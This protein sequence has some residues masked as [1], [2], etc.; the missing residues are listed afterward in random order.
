MRR[1]ILC[2]RRQIEKILAADSPDTD[3]N[4]LLTA[5]LTQ[6]S[7]FQHER[8]IHLIVTVTFALIVVLLMHI[9]LFAP[10]SSLL[11]LIFF[12]AAAL[13]LCFYILHYYIL[14]TNVQYFYTQYDRILSK[15]QACQTS[16]KQ[17][18]EN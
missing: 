6:V 5:H 10:E 12:L 9:M 17:G 16:A 8:L 18:G 7:F 2:Y 13:F 3:W 15:C 4:L 14:E 1:R 11:L